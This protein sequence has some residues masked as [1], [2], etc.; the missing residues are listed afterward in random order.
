MRI[1]IN[2]AVISAHNNL[3]LMMITL[4]FYLCIDVRASHATIDDHI[5]KII[6]HVFLRILDLPWRP[7]E[8]P[9]LI[10]CSAALPLALPSLETAS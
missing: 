10:G 5:V 2:I 6:I 4:V 7:A 3:Y 9:T 1:F 8:T